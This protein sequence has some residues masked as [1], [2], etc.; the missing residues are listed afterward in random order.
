VGSGHP[1]PGGEGFLTDCFEAIHTN[2]A[3]VMADCGSAADAAASVAAGADLLGTTLS[4][5]TEERPRTEG[6]DFEFLSEPIAAC[7]IPVV[8]E[9]RI[10]TPDESPWH[11]GE[12]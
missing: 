7:D 3:L 6:P 8:A 12:P 5:H 9:G 2:G 1:A 11:S 4:G 10:R